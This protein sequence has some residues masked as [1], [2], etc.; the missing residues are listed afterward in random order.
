[1]LSIDTTCV[2]REL[3][4]NYMTCWRLAGIGDSRVVY[5]RLPVNSAPQDTSSKRHFPILLYQIHGLLHLLRY[6]FC[7]DNFVLKIVL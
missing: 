1:M 7:V 3:V 4:T 6:V 2:H 5:K